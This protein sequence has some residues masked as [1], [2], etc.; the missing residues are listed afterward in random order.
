M[1]Y[2]IREKG[3]MRLCDAMG[4][5]EGEEPDVFLSFTA[6]I[7]TNL[8]GGEEDGRLRSHTSCTQPLLHSNAQ[9]CPVSPSMATG[10]ISIPEMSLQAGLPGQY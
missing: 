7:S 2:F 4:H 8:L 5:R 1:H 9:C 10:T 6:Q 3:P